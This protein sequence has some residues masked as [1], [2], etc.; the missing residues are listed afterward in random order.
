MIEWNTLRKVKN[1]IKIERKTNGKK[2][3]GPKS[4][5]ELCSSGL[6]VFYVPSIFFNAQNDKI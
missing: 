1:R 5:I 3:S 4:A 6:N 2:I